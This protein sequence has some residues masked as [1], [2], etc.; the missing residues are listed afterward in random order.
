MVQEEPF[1]DDALHDQVERVDRDRAPAHVRIDN[2]SPM[3]AER[4][5]DR[6]AALACN[7]VDGERHAA[8]SDCCPDPVER[9]V[10]IYDHEVA[11]NGLQ[12]GDELRAT[13]EIDRLNTPRFGDCDKRPTDT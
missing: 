6:G 4:G 3:L 13:H 2:E 8:G 1:D 9:A 7:S 10:F 12:L 5:G 11:A